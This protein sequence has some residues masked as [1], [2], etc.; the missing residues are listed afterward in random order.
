MKGYLYINHHKVGE[1]NF[2]IIDESMGGIGGILATHEAYYQ[3][4]PAIQQQCDTKGI[5]NIED[6]DYKILLSDHTE[7]QPTGGIGVT[8]VQGI[9]EIYVESAGL[10]IETLRKIKTSL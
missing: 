8:D 6:F 1:I 5:S 7:L 2:G 9:D 4:Q 10:D 3:Y